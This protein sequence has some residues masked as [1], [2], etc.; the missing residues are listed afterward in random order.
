MKM[1]INART[2]PLTFASARIP[3]RPLDL[4]VLFLPL[5]GFRTQAALVCNPFGNPL[6][7]S[8][9]LLTIDT[10]AHYNNAPQMD[11]VSARLG[12]HRP[13][14]ESQPALR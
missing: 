4:Y 11:F 9:P 8:K 6:V 1:Y 7:I 13:S 3:L 5:C 12:V 10:A 14:F 2:P